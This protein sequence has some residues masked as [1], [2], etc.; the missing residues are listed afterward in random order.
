V[1]EGVGKCPLTPRELDVVRRLALSN[2][3]IGRGLGIRYSTVKNVITGVGIKMLGYWDVRRGAGVRALLL[4][5]A[6]KWGWIELDEV[7][8]D[9][10]DQVAR[11]ADVSG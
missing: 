2:A 9:L 7:V 10:P 5:L 4:V 3:E 11:A 1:V 8:T 6:L